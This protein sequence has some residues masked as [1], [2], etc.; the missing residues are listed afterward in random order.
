MESPGDDPTAGRQHQDDG[1]STSSTG[2]SDQEGH[3][4][5]SQISEADRRASIVPAPR[6]DGDGGTFVSGFT[7]PRC[8]PSWAPATAG[9]I[10]TAAAAITTTTTTTT[11]TTERTT[12]MA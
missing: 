5:S 10:T 11:T 1:R 4:A 7:V 6:G 8:A 9:N 12:T 2:S 3:E